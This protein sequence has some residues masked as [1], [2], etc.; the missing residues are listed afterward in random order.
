MTPRSKVRRAELPSGLIVARQEMTSEQK[1][2]RRSDNKIAA[3]S[4]AMHRKRKPHGRQ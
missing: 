1:K 4:R 3:E 2:E